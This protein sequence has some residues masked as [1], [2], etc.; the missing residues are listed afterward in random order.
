MNW[1][2]CQQTNSRCWQR[3][4]VRLSQSAHSVGTF[5]V[6]CREAGVKG[7]SPSHGLRKAR[8]VLLAES[9]VPLAE[10]LMAYLGHSRPE[11]S[12]VLYKQG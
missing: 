11:E 8:A 6:W 2:N 10:E 4:R 7:S 9:L 3:G 5:G 1:I 12:A